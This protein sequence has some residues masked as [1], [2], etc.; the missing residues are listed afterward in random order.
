M[1]LTTSSFLSLS[2]PQRP[3]YPGDSTRRRL[4]F[5]R[6]RTARPPRGHKFACALQRD[7]SFGH[8]YD[9]KLV[10]ED[11]IVLRM[12]IHEIKMSEKSQAEAAASDWMEW[13]K[14]YY[15]EDYDSDICEAVGLLQSRLMNTRPSLAL[16]MLGLVSL[17]V[18]ISLGV[19]L[20]HLVDAA[21]VVLVGFH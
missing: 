5:D 15:C 10:D 3:Y 14:K 16:A 21:K 17:S 7:A 8:G 2:L 6:R 12:R 18:P 20:L 19:V 13:E 9:G 11:M 1:S 4:G